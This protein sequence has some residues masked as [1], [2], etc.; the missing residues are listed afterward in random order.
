[1]RWILLGLQMLAILG[2]AIA[3]VVAVNF[4]GGTLWQWLAPSAGSEPRLA[5]DL[6][7]WMASITLAF[8]VIARFM[9]RAPRRFVVAA[10]LA[11]MALALWA[12]HE[13]WG[14][15]PH[16]FT[17]GMLLSP[18]LGAGLAMRWVRRGAPGESPAVT[19]TRN[20]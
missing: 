14:E 17:V 12:A 5:W 2:L 4:A 15:Y 7:W 13:M 18:L 9:P 16:W 3:A 20:H 19:L 10:L 1:M 6:G 8:W 11:L